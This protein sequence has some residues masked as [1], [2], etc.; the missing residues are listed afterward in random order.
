MFKLKKFRNS[1]QRLANSRESKKRSGTANGTLTE[2]NIKTEQK[3]RDLFMEN[4]NKDM[5]RK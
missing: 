5:K 2:Q 1:F 4:K 3:V